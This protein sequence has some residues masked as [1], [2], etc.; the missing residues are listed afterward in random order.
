MQNHTLTYTS[1]L[2]NLDKLPTE[3]IEFYPDERNFT[4]FPLKKMSYKVR[5]TC[6]LFSNE[7]EELAKRE[8]TFTIIF[9]ES[10]LNQRCNTQF[11]TQTIADPDKP[12]F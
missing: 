9:L 7:G 1:A 10:A 6:H 2:E 12:E 11:T 4:V 3:F 5:V 8:I